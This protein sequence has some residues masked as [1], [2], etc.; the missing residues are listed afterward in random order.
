MHF[1]TKKTIRL[2]L[3]IPKWKNSCF[4]I[5]IWGHN[6]ICIVLNTTG[7]YI[8]YIRHLLEEKSTPNL[9][10]IKSTL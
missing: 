5:V 4:D 3:I 2:F 8:D 1:Q 6:S 10:V 7:R 9:F